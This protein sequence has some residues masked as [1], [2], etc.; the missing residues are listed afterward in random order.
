MTFYVC[1]PSQQITNCTNIVQSLRLQCIEGTGREGD[2]FG[3][4]MG[5]FAIAFGKDRVNP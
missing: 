4:V 5:R 3:N 2:V 1:Y